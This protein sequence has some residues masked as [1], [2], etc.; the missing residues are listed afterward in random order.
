MEHKFEG[1]YGAKGM[2]FCG[3]IWEFFRLGIQNCKGFWFKKYFIDQHPRE[4]RINKV[5]KPKPTIITI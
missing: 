4:F 5:R 2:E 3:Q 1:S